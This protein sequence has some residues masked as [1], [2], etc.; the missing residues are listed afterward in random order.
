M[1]PAFLRDQIERS[2]ANLR[3]E[4]IDCYLI[5]E[6]EVCLASV[7][8][9]AFKARVCA[10]FEALESAVADGL[11]GCYGLCTW[12]GLL[13][14]HTERS[15]LS[16]LDIFDW[17]LD[18]GSADHHLRALQLPYSLAMAEA[19]KLPSQ[20]GPGGTTDAILS[21]LR[22][23]GTAVFASTPLV[24]G[25]AL[26]RTPEVVTRAFPDLKSD[27]QRSLQFVRSTPGITSAVVGM[28]DPDHID[29]N[30]ALARHAPADPEQIE[31]LFKPA[32]AG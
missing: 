16:L 22:G 7:G 20:L 2:R 10:A 24:Q 19:L 4:T 8:P 9:D 13:R 18:V 5:E 26:G 28:R 27:A 25:R 12:D 31:S 32:E 15:H 6:P 23:T 17:A 11:I 14:P 30:L 3:L 29:E 21:S 1:A